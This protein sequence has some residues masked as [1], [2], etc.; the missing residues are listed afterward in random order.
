MDAAKESCNAVINA[1]RLPDMLNEWLKRAVDRLGR[2][3]I[4]IK[5]S[6]NQQDLKRWL[7]D[8]EFEIIE[9]DEDFKN[10]GEANQEE[11]N[12]IATSW[13]VWTAGLVMLTTVYC[14]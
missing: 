9:I 1:T 2:T 3:E 10:G 7:S 6:G 13:R 14:K 11:L 5:A 8:A 4:D 12:E